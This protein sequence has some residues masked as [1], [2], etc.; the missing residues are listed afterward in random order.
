MAYFP[1]QRRVSKLTGDLSQSQCN[2]VHQTPKVLKGNP[3][4]K[5]HTSLSMSMRLQTPIQPMKVSTQP[6][7]VMAKSLQID[8]L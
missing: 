4:S 8:L 2:Q 6:F 3:A 7:S 1:T 5:K